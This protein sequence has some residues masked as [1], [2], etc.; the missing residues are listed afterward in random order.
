M[1]AIFINLEKKETLRRPEL[2]IYPGK[3]IEDGLK[4]LDRFHAVEASVDTSSRQKSAVVLQ[5]PSAGK[6]LGC[7]KS[8]GHFEIF[9]INLEEMKK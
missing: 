7:S 1:A 4:V 3:S 5:K 6:R 2:N 8:E 9:K